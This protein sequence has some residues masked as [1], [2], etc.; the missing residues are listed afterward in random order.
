MPSRLA[1]QAT[2]A[3]EGKQAASGRSVKYKQATEA[4]QAT[5]GHG[6]K[7]ACTPVSQTR[8]AGRV[9]GNQADGGMQAFHEGREKYKLAGGHTQVDRLIRHAGQAAYI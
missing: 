3:K 7:H 6:V 1:R 5:S 4:M 8:K 9:V 2:K